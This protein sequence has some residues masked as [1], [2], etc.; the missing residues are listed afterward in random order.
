MHRSWP[1]ALV[2]VTALSG[3]AA[4]SSCTKFRDTSV[5][6]SDGGADEGGVEASTDAGDDGGPS[7]FTVVNAVPTGEA[8]TSV[9]GADKDDVFAVGTNGV[10]YEYYQGSWQRLQNVMGRD[11][12]GV[13]GRS[14]SDVYA[15][16]VDNGTGGGI[17]TH[18]DGTSWTDQQQT[19]VPL[20]GVWG[21][22]DT[23][24][25]VG[26]QGMI[27]G[28]HT[29]VP[30]WTMVLGDAGLPANPN[31]P[32]SPDEPILWG[33]AGSSISDIALPA[34]QDRIF[35]ITDAENI[36]YLDPTVDRTVSFRS[37]FGVPTDPESY[38]FGSNYFG[39]VWLTTQGPPD[40]A[41][42][43]DDLY[44]I[45]QDRSPAGADQLFIYGIWG[46]TTQFLFTGDL[47]RIYSYQAGPDVFAR[48]SSP[49]DSTLYGV[50]GSSASDVWIVGQREVIL[51]G[52]LPTQ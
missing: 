49:T 1:L 31:V 47:G 30:G 41:L 50:W 35:H 22:G 10:M 9:W 2:T 36:N 19:P 43:D 40:A 45:F 38:F 13:W 18:F 15:V 28:Q 42:V 39:V 14:A 24:L 3:A 33:V 25:A 37:V 11:Y 5:G 51:H 27:Y 44:Q 21:Q 26:S 23:I 48:V 6:S 4:V 34:D 16:G 7:P 46:T 8:L 12:E 29:E 32:P 20:Y 17:I 52:S